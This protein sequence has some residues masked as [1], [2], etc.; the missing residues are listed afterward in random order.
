MSKT[1]AKYLLGLREAV[2]GKGAETRL[3]KVRYISVGFLGPGLPMRDHHRHH[4]GPPGGIFLTFLWWNETK[5]K[6]HITQTTRAF[7]T[8]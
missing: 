6:F 4:R 3:L 8:L 1:V 7:S 5:I 2:T